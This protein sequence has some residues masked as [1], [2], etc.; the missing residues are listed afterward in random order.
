MSRIGQAEIKIPEGVTVEVRDGGRFNYKEVVVEGPKGTLAESIRRGVEV[1]VEKGIVTVKRMNNSKQSRAFHGLYRSLIAN[2][3]T[4]VV[5]GYSKELTIVGIGFRA[6]SQGNKV[7]FSLGFS[8]KIEYEPPEGIV[9]E[10]NDQTNIVVK[11]ISKQLVGEVAAKI[12]S[13]RKPE[14]YKGKGI[15]YKDEIVR[16]KAAKTTV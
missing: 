12:R 8:H 5:D 9:V 3:V 11:G 6:E 16:R 2:M 7:V 1:N 10:V 4:G 13:F 14:P 15:R